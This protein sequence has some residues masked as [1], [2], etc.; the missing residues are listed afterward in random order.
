MKKKEFKEGLK[1]I[2]YVKEE[3]PVFQIPPYYIKAG[4]SWVETGE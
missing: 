2:Q 3:A 4:K 1:V